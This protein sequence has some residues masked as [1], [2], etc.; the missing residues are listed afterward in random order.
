M[1]LKTFS[2]A[3]NFTA[4]TKSDSTLVTCDGIYVG[5]AG[6]IALSQSDTATAVTFVGVPAGTFLPIRLKN[7]RIMSTNTTATEIVALTW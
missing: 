3:V 1:G 4:V 5:G 7:G 2:S 6:N